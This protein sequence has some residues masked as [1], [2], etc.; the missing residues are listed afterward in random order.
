MFTFKIIVVV[1]LYVILSWLRWRI[2]W[3][4]EEKFRPLLPSNFKVALEETWI[5]LN[6]FQRFLMVSFCV[7]FVC[8]LIF[9]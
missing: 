2:A 9:I 8:F 1:L 3:H 4:Y 7:G 6:S 5:Y